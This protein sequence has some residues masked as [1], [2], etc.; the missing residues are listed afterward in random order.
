MRR[1]AFAVLSLSLCAIPA[2]ARA[3]T[4]VCAQ[5]VDLTP[6]AGGPVDMRAAR[7]APAD[8]YFGAYPMSVLGIGN[9]LRRNGE[10]VDARYDGDAATTGPLACAVDSIRAWERAY[11]ADPW[12]AKDLLSLEMVYLRARG[13]EAREFASRTEAWLEHD[14]P[15]SN[16]V[17]PARLA[18]G[19]RPHAAPVQERVADDAYPAVAHVASPWDRFES[20]ETDGR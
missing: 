8:E 1:L 5:R 10:A 9:T 14:Y 18:L 4:D 2:I 11:P 15:L 16:Y 7:P 12:I 19:R 17:E 6:V 20:A 13:G 3:S